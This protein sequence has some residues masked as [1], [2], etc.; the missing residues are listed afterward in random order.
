[1]VSLGVPLPLRDRVLLQVPTA[2]PL[3]GVAPPLRDGEVHLWRIHVPDAELLPSDWLLL[4]TDEERSRAARKRLPLDACRTLT[5]RGCLRRLLGSY[6]N[7][8]PATIALTTSVNGKPRLAAQLKSTLEF[9]VSHSGN[10]IVIGITRG[11]SL[12]VDVECHREMEFDQLVYSF[13]SQQ[14]RRAWSAIPPRARTEAF[15]SAWTRKEAYLKALGLGLSRS[16]DTFAV[17]FDCKATSELVWCASDS[18]APQRWL[19]AP[20]DFAPGYSCAIAVGITASVLQTFTF[21]AL[22]RST[23]REISSAHTSLRNESGA[24]TIFSPT[25]FTSASVSQSASAN[26]PVHS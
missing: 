24:G 15:F 5:S 23:S 26:L 20:V 8:P 2:W 19:I 11:I 6:L 22:C 13:F 21:S 18:S 1:M 16:L 25:A 10:W 7:L 12:G 17:A 4:L 3:L 9:N 14:E